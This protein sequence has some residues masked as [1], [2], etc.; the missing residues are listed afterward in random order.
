MRSSVA[1]WYFEIIEQAF[2]LVK[3]NGPATETGCLQR[4]DT[5]KDLFVL[6]INFRQI[7]QQGLRQQ[8]GKVDLH[9]DSPWG[10]GRFR[11]FT[12]YKKGARKNSSKISPNSGKDAVQ[13]PSRLAAENP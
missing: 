10:N 7:D 4:L 11:K 1:K 12:Q 2:E 5:P 6:C 3:G 13:E 8:S 9:S